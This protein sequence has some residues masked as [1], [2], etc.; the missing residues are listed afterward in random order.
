MDRRDFLATASAALAAGAAVVPV[1][2]ATEHDHP[3]PPE[4]AEMAR[5]TDPVLMVV[6]PGMT[7]L[8]L[9][10][11]QYMFANVL[12]AKV[13]LVGKTREPVPCDTGFS[14]LPT[15]TFDEARRRTRPCCSFLEAHRERW[16]SSRMRQV[17]ASSPT[18][19]RAR[20]M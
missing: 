12:G 20:P 3:M 19:G 9:V 17:C 16:P 5:R 14:I 2:Q 13:H 7:A 4:W 6:Y 18:A 11:P 8:D 10:G 1:A 15:M